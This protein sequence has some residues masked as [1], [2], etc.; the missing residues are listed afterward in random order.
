MSQR[1]YYEVLGVSRD[2]STENIKKAYRKV[3]LKY[4]P[5]RNQDDKTAEEQFKEA[6]SAYE[7]LGNPEKRKKY[8][9]FGHAGVGN[10][11]GH[12]G[13]HMTVEDIFDQ[14]GDLF[15]GSPFEAFFGGPR[16]RGKRNTIRRG[17]DLRIKLKVTLKEI[18]LG[19]MKKIKVRRMVMDPRV[20]F[21]SCVSCRGTGELRRQVRTMLGQMISTS[22]CGNCGGDGRMIDYRPPGAD[23]SG[24]K[25]QEEVLDIGLPPGVSEGVQLSMR[26]K[27]NDPPGGGVAGNLLIEIKEIKDDVLQRQ[28]HHIVYNLSL[29]FA[30]AAMGKEVTIPC[31][32][33]MVSIKVKA[34]T[35]SGTTLRLRGKGIPDLEN[36]RSR[37]DQLILINVWVPTRLNEEERLMMERLDK[38][39]N[40]QPPKKGSSDEQSSFYERVMGMFK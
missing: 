9:Q 33:G 30:E 25:A 21:K 4:H 23:L 20:T 11:G 28:G 29:G 15:G 16:G 38:A 17:N 22:V 18:T 3:A 5:D 13:Q 31:I 7:V 36:K 12:R 34:G 14:F 10:G 40:F 26:E 6:A 27:G 8:D 32:D 24:L 37:G 39:E 1:D 35:Q 19:A 2:D